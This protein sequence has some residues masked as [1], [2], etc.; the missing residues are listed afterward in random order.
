V[1]LRSVTD[2]RIG[3]G[4]GSRAFGAPR[5][6]FLWRLI[7]NL[8]FAKLWGGITSQFTLK[9]AKMQMSSLDYQYTNNTIILFATQ[10]KNYNIA[11]SGGLALLG[12]CCQ[13]KIEHQIRK[14]CVK[15]LILRNMAGRERDAGRLYESG[16][17]Q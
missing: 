13:W 15:R 1:V 10:Y 5:N 7:I 9:R 3:H 8:K 4:L 11:V 14:C 12:A 6:S 2:L 16:Y 17:K